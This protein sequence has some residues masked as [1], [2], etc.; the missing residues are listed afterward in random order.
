MRRISP[1]LLLLATA[2]L[3][4]EL[5]LHPAYFEQSDSTLTVTALEINENLCNYAIDGI[6]YNLKPLINRDYD[7]NVSLESEGVSYR[8]LFNFCQTI[9]EETCGL[10]STLAGLVYMGENHTCYNLS[11]GP[12]PRTD[13]DVI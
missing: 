8:V 6:Y 13:V 4:K 11:S 3:G 2:T 5:F 12:G 7:Y 1:C 10:D 9:R